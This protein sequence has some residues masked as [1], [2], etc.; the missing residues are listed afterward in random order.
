[1][2]GHEERLS[3]HGRRGQPP[4]PAH[5][6]AGA[7]A[8]RATAA[9][10]PL[11]RPTPPRAPPPAAPPPPPRYGAWGVDL[12]ALDRTATPGEDFDQYVN[13]GWKRKTEIPADQPSTGV[14]FDVFNRS[15]AQIRA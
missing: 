6:R 11:P 4:L 12:G 9:A 15:Q 2:V 8:R 7:A 13:G 10:A 3:P 14:G 5:P 1:M